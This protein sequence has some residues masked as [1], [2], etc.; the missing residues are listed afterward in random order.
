LDYNQRE[1]LRRT[2][3]WVSGVCNNDCVFCLDDLWKPGRA[4]GERPDL[5]IGRDRLDAFLRER[6]RSNEVCITGPDPG[7]CRELEDI[8]ARV[9]ELG[10][11]RVA[12]VTNGRGM[13]RDGVAAA[14]VRAGVTRFEISIHGGSAEVHDAATRRP[15]SFDA[16]LRGLGAALALRND[17]GAL[18]VE[19]VTVVYRGNLGVVESTVE[20]LLATGPD[21]LSVNLV[22]PWGEALAR[23]DEVVPPLSEAASV[24][25]ALLRRFGAQ[26]RLNLDGVPPCLLPGVEGFA[27]NR[28]AVDLASGSGELYDSEGPEQGRVYGERCGACLHRPVCNGVYRA[29]AERHG[30]AV[31][32]PTVLREGERATETERRAILA[33]FYDR[34]EKRYRERRQAVER[35]QV[36]HLAAALPADRPVELLGTEPLGARVLLAGAPHRL[37]WT[38]DGQIAARHRVGP[39]V[40]IPD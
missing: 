6:D 7:T 14:L 5:V 18:Q 1:S 35:A 34:W 37:R 32:R 20:R 23:F 19:L 15:G 22:E 17:G 26:A 29:T 2:Q 10:F 25:R 39:F 16:A 27:G 38:P 36:Q 33:L 24:L 21:R 31:L 28:E 12:I 3:F 30:L 40:L 13:G 4:P 11:E 8:V 9:R